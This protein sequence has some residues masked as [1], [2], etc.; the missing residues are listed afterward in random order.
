MEMIQIIYNGTPKEFEK[1]TTYYDISRAFGLNEDILGVKINN[2]VHYLGERAKKSSNVEFVDYTDQ[3]GR[4][5]YKSGLQFI[6]EVAVKEIFDNVEVKYQHS[7]PKGI[8]AS[9][10]Y[11]EE[12]STQDISKIK[13]KMSSIISDNLPIRKITVLKTEAIEYYEKNNYVEKANNIQNILD[14]VVNIYG[15]K[16]YYNYYYS[17]MPYKTGAITKYEIKYVG[18]NRIILIIPDYNGQMPDYSPCDNIIQSFYQGKCW[19]DDLDM[20]YLTNLNQIVGNGKIKDF[21]KSCELMFSLNVANV[22]KKISE[23]RNIKFVMIAGPSSSGKTTTTKRL[24]DYLRANGYDPIQISTDDYFVDRDVNPKDE[25]GNNDYECLTA[26]DLEVFNKDL[27]DLLA[28]KSVRLP[29]YNFIT[30]KREMSEKVVQMKDNSI[31]LIEGLHTLNDELTPKINPKYKYKI[32]LSPFIPLNIDQHN[33]ISTTDLRLL[34]RMVR[35][36]RTRGYDVIKTMSNWLNVRKGEEKYIFPYIPQADIIVNTALPYEIGVL[37]V[38]VEPL[39]L[40][41]SV[42]SVYYEEARRLINFLKP[43]FTIP[44]EYVND[45]SILREFIGGNY[46]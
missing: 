7:V 11:K 28:G 20:K 5:I 31:F 10:D 14:K 30:G 13:D 34:R 24:A 44:S 37:K 19:L 17:D 16:G 45:S 32:Y 25:F 41:V 4:K 8:L 35:D 9:I 26:I 2:V 6:F 1:N 27:E 42:K 46:D 36:N 33:Y 18:K 15:L 39:L 43:F 21:I 23:N 3:I 38:Y 12:L 29:Q 22:A 40:S